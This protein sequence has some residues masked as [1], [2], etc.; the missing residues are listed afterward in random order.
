M[1][2]TDFVL[3]DRENR[4][5][6]IEKLCSVY[7]TIVVVKAN[8]PGSE[9]NSYLSYLLVNVF[10]GVLKKHN[11]KL[12]RKIRSLDGPYSIFTTNQDSSIV[13]EEMIRTED[14]HPLGRFIDIDVYSKDY[15]HNRSIQ[16]KCFICDRDAFLCIKEQKHSIQELKCF[17]ELKVL[18]YY[19]HI[20]FAMIDKSIMNELNLE[21]KFGLVTPSSQGTH[22]D[23]SYDLMVKAKNVIKPYFLR[24]FYKSIKAD[25][26]FKDVVLDLKKLGIE[27]E[28]AMLLATNNINAYKGLIFNLGLFVCAF[29]K[30]LT[31][32]S[33]ENIFDYTK[34]LAKLILEDGNHEFDTFG[35]FAY[36][37]YGVKGAKGEALSGFNTVQ[38]SLKID[39]HN[40]HFSKLQVLIYFIVNVE[41]TNFLKRSISFDN[42]LNVKKMFANVNILNQNDIRELDSYCI[43]NNLTFGG[44]ADLLVVRFF[45]EE[46]KEF[47]WIID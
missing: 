5:R 31:S 26:D 19:E 41:D 47:F 46:I 28:K 10:L 25:E 39:L 29:A 16:R 22:P 21:P 7:N 42:Y 11:F 38:N 9:K 45:L 8:I 18:D 30:K 12:L 33:D 17:V 2:K 43:K 13:K 15:R 35:D 44:S 36:S 34:I 32:F 23:M 14:C 40:S 6:F 3:R 27:A 20:V 24:M 1:S 37:K 4:S